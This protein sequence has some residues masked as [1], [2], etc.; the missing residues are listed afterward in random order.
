[1]AKAI[2]HVDSWTLLGFYAFVFVGAALHE[3]LEIVWPALRRGTIFP[4][5]LLRKLLLFIPFFL[6]GEVTYAIALWWYS[7]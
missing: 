7:S 4:A 5:G 6:A 2:R 3:G 1:M